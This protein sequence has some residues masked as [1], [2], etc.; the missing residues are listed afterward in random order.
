M[1]AMEPMKKQIQQHLN[2]VSGHSR[3]LRLALKADRERQGLSHAAVASM[4]GE[5]RTRAARSV[6]PSAVVDDGPA[7]STISMWERFENHPNIADFAAWARVLGR[8]LVVELDDAGLPRVAVLLQT[9]EAVEIARTVD[10]WPK[11]RREALVT[12]VRGWPAG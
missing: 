7:G 1:V 4:I 3:R 5:W 12:L 6:D 9:Q 10:S 2:E 8:R 11:D